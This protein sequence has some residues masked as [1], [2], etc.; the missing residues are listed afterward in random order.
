[1]SWRS[2]SGSRRGFAPVAVM[3]FRILRLGARA[4][5]MIV[6]S[7]IIQSRDVVAQV[8]QVG[9]QVRIVSHDPGGPVDARAREISL[10]RARDARIEIRG[11][12]WSSCTMYL[13]LPRTCVSRDAVLGFHGP[14]SGMRGIGLIPA[15]FE[16]A[17]Q[18]MARHYPE[19]LRGWFLREGRARTVGFHR[20]SGRQLIAMGLAECRDG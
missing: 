12:C 16:R 19:P 14:G 10:L 18:M 8:A 2:A 15:E 4:L 13:A 7:V 17:S 1:M 5:A 20:F 11:D 3:A 6:V 9:G